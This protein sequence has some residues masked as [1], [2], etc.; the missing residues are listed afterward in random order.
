MDNSFCNT[1]SFSWEALD[2][3]T[4]CPVCGSHRINQYQVEPEFDEEESDDDEEDY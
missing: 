2:L 3:Y 4:E 1:C